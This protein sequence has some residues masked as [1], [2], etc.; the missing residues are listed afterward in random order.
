MA[1]TE[2]NTK[3]IGDGE[4][5]RADL[6]VNESSKAVIAR[7]IAGDN[8]TISSTGADTGTGDVTINAPTGGATVIKTV[9][10]DY[11]ILITDD[12]ILANNTVVIELDLPTAVGNSGK[13]IIVKRIADIRKRVKIIANGSEEIDG[14]AE[15]IIN[16]K[17][18][19]IE[20]LS[21]GSNW[22]I[23]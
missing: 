3:Q 23:I 12:I 13:R 22:W 11:T 19:S 2:I 5:T 7:I 17:Y 9:T 4:V 21:D 14:E 6:N 18:T 20:L 8:I 16:K 15:V 10:A 1:K